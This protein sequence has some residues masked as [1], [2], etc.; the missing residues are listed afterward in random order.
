MQSRIQQDINNLA[1]EINLSALKG[2]SVLLTGS[3]GLFGKY[4]AYL[5]VLLNSKY[6]YKIKLYCLSLH[7]PDKSFNEIIKRD[8][9][10]FFKKKDLTKSFK[11]I[12]Q[13]D[14]IFHTACYAQPEKFIKNILQTITL[15]IN[16]T[17]QLLELAKKHD[18][19]F[20][21]FS[22]A[23][24]Y[25]KIPKTEIPVNETYKG[26]IDSN[27]VRS[28][29]AQSKHL[30]ESICEIYRR[31]YNTSVYIARI[32]HTYGPGTKSNDKRLI[33]DII[34]QARNSGIIK[35]KDGGQ[36][37]K[38]WGYVSDS[39]KMLL[40]VIL[41]GK[42]FIYNVGGEDTL[43]VREVAQEIARQLSVPVKIAKN[44]S[45]HIGH[46]NESQ[47]LKLD[48]SKYYKEFGKFNRINFSEGI[49]RI[50]NHTNKY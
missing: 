10:I 39:V 46:F 26:N 15:N 3:N 21:F 14:Y 9:N 42:D 33:S 50:L 43:S 47:I 25:G 32:S 41:Y 44:P 37:K 49:G 40:N 12:N 30:G 2:K 16:T 24:I 23:E 34:Q 13:V 38:T 27:C 20:L 35:L 28:L 1:N 8:K 31:N 17:Y 29:Y 11:F 4:I 48:I 45:K 19:K 22:S 7:N 18:A 5:I 36:A 6:N